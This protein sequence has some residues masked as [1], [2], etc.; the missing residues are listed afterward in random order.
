MSNTLHIDRRQ[1]IAVTAGALA[2]AAPARASKADGYNIDLARRHL[3][4]IWQDG[5]FERAADILHPE[6]V[7]H[8]PAPGQAPGIA[9]L[10]AF[11][12]LIKKAIPDQKFELVKLFS[13]GD[14]V[15][16]HWILRGTHTGPLGIIPPTG[17]T[18]EF[19]GTDIVR[20]ADRRIIEI[21][22]VEDMLTMFAQLGLVTPPRLS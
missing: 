7:D 19:H 9:G 15:V 4:D 1:A 8:N 12:A 3:I 11:A 22:H 17:R 2:L 20:I 21:W 6:F 18:V 10:V 14:M 5:R 13:A 16:D